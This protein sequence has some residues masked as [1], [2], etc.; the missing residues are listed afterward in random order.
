M[1]RMTPEVGQAEGRRVGHT[2]P[3]YALLGPSLAV[4][5]DPQSGIGHLRD[6]RRQHRSGLGQRKRS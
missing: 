2:V 3:E 1:G 5:P 6:G 4:A